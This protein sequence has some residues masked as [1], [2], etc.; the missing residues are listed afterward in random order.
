MVDGTVAA[1]FHLRQRCLGH[2][3][4]GGQQIGAGPRQ[5]S[6]MMMD[7]LRIATQQGTRQGVRPF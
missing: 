7:G 4:I 2:G 5:R 1:P 3:V 6:Q